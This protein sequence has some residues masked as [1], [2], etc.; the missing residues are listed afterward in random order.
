M[1]KSAR[2]FARCLTKHLVAV[3]ENVWNLLEIHVPRLYRLQVLGRKV[4]VETFWRPRI[5]SSLNRNPKF[6]LKAYLGPT[7]PTVL[8][9]VGHVPTITE[10]LGR[11]HTKPYLN[12]SEKPV[13]GNTSK[14][15]F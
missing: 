6:S 13:P 1:C 4:W 8:G 11:V 2:V 9:V 15:I 12:T 5:Y 10:G 14:H 7:E 3:E